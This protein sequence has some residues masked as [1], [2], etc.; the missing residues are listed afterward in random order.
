MKIK[1]ILV[2][3]S[4]CFNKI[5]IFLFS[6]FTTMLQKCRNITGYNIRH[7]VMKKFLIY[8]SVC[9]LLLFYCH[10]TAIAQSGIPFYNGLFLSSDSLYDA[11]EYQKAISH[12]LSVI[13]NNKELTECDFYIIAR[14]YAL[15][16]MSD[17]AF[18]YL[19]RYVDG[20]NKDYRSVFV[21]DDFRLLRKNK[22]EWTKISDRIE[23]IFLKGYDTSINGEYALELFR[24][25]IEN[26][27]YSMPDISY[28]RTKEP[29][30]RQICKKQTEV[31]KDFDK[32]VRK[33]GFPTPS[34]VGDYAAGFAFEIMMYPV[35]EEEYVITSYSIHYTKLYDP[36]CAINA[37]NV[38]S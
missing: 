33:Y 30:L 19:N 16:E 11:G 35:I 22:P 12:R 25:G 5:C 37:L 2:I 20:T 13:E 18:Y 1:K 6:A 7:I 36:Q 26:M 29:S 34:M 17:S 21:D 24:L 15:L 8:L 38:L 23:D 3:L 10:D 27:R 9:I 32:L 28:K 31:R 14:C 4:A